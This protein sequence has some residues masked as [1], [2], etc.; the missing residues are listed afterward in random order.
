M[1]RSGLLLADPLHI[2]KLAVLDSVVQAILV[3]CEA[4]SAQP[5]HHGKVS[6]QSGSSHATTMDWAWG[7]LS[8]HPLHQ[9]ELPSSS[10]SKHAPAI[11]WGILL[12][13]PP[14][15]M[16]MRHSVHAQTVASHVQGGLEEPSSCSISRR[17]KLAA[18]SN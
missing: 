5:L 18:K 3:R 16:W 8:A 15:T 10:C 6:S 13:Q 4:F 2:F 14:Q 9:A 17:P 11:P 7:I 12:A 1:T